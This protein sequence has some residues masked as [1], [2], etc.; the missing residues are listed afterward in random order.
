MKI[1]A[2]KIATALKNHFPQIRFAFLFG[3]A[4]DGEIRKGGDLDVGVYLS[5]KKDLVDLIPKILGKIED[6]TGNEN[7]DLK[8]MNDADPL[9]AMEMLK[10]KRLFVRDEAMDQYAAY[11]SLTCRLYEDKI[12][13]M[14]KQ[15]EYRGYDVQWDH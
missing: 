8:I 14:K 15:L 7:I 10:G 9:L 3:S 13:W 1:D 2:E 4:Q 6:T 11:Y 5:P 12:Y